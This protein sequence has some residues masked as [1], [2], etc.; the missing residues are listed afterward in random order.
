MCF[1]TLWNTELLKKWRTVKNGGGE[2][3]EGR[4]GEKEEKKTTITILFFIT[5]ESFQIYSTFQLGKYVQSQMKAHLAD[6]PFD[7]KIREKN[8]K[9][10][11]RI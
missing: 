11:R 4:K 8:F 5:W 2:G 7:Y 10:P 9:L 1:Y 3:W 6:S